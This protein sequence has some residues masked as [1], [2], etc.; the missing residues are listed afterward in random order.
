M[1]NERWGLTRLQNQPRGPGRTNGLGGNILRPRRQLIAGGMAY[2][3][4]RATTDAEMIA[5]KA[6]R[7]SAM[8]NALGKRSTF[9]SHL[10]EPRKMQPKIT[11]RAVVK[12]R[13]FRGISCLE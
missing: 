1:M 5:L 4:P 2:E 13:A 3:T 12:M 9:G 6:L 7:A 8:I 11:T 10:D